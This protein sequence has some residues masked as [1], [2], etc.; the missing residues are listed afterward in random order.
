[1]SAMEEFLRRWNDPGSE[2]LIGI[3]D[4]ASS[5]LR[6]A[7]PLDLHSAPEICF[8]TP[9]GE[10]P[11]KVLQKSWGSEPGYSHD[12]V[13][14]F[15]IVEFS[16]AAIHKWK[17]IVPVGGPEDQ[18]HNFSAEFGYMSVFDQGSFDRLS[19]IDVATKGCLYDEFL[20]KQL[21]DQD[22][23]WLVDL[24]NKPPGKKLAVCYSGRGN[25]IYPA[26]MGFDSSSRPVRIVVDFEIG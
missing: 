17:Y 2:T 8:E 24:A 20:A 3:Q 5:R 19:A 26:F 15:L 14:A 11:V 21:D 6:M 22:L 23:C 7:D 4:F 13:N 12:I 1:M 10:F 16:R 9:I 18:M 25:G